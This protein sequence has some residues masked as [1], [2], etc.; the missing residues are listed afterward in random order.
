MSNDLFIKAEQAL[1]NNEFPKAEALF[2]QILSIEPGNPDALNYL[3]VVCFQQGKNEDSLNTF[4]KL[5][6]V[7]PDYPDLSFNLAN[8]LKLTGNYDEAAN[9]ARKAIEA[10]PEIAD[11]YNI[12]AS[13]LKLQGNF[14]E[15]VKNFQA[16]L[17]L[18][19]R[20]FNIYYNLAILLKEQGDLAGAAENYQNAIRLKPSFIQAYYNLAN[21][22]AD[23]DDFT[24]AEINYRKAVELNPRFAKAHYSLAYLYQ[25]NGNLDKAIEHY[26]IT[27]QIEPD[28][29]EACF[30]L[31]NLL[32]ENNR[33][34]QAIELYNKTIS[35]DDKFVKA[36]CNL[37]FAYETLG[38]TEKAKEAFSRAVELDPGNSLLK[39]HLQTMIPVVPFDNRE[40]DQSR[41]NLLYVIGNFSLPKEE[42]DLVNLQIYNVPPSSE[43][44]YQGRDDREIKEKYASLFINLFPLK[45]DAF[46]LAG[47]PQVIR[48]AGLNAS[49]HSR[50]PDIPSRKPRIGF[51]VTRG[52]E[53]IF[54]KCMK[55]ILNN[56]P[57]EKFSYT[58]IFNNPSREADF[59]NGITNPACGFLCM[60]RQFDK[61]V[62]TVEAGNFD[63]LYYWEAGSDTTNYFLPFFRPAP[64]QCTSWGWP[65]TS[66]IP[67]MDYFV[68]SELLETEESQKYYSEKLYKLK[69]L[70][71]FYF[72]S[73]I[74][75]YLTPL[76]FFGLPENRHIY[77]CVQNLRKVHPDFD[78]LISGILQAD[79]DAI[80][81]FSANRHPG[82]TARLKNR[83][84]AKFP[85]LAE[86]IVFIP[87]PEGYE[88]YLSLLANSHVSL[89][90]VHYSGA[91]TTYESFAVGLPVVTLPGLFHRGRYT[92]AA[93]CGMGIMD[94]V[95]KDESDYIQ[96]AVKIATD[97]D[98]RQEL[99]KKIMSSCDILFENKKAIAELT[100]FFEFAL[101][102]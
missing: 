4:K 23:Q 9:Y 2:R 21:I 30:F 10:Q 51:V 25:V 76:S 97:P 69:S 62:K 100:E 44:N 7:K 28:H 40:I 50:H 86:R 68:S 80:V 42:I 66:G 31:A 11:N 52:H 5:L 72:R 82:I 29:A 55:G 90:T 101:N 83:F 6:A 38:L 79:P 14:P 59:R 67:E 19:P 36:H 95:A 78:G 22:C 35:L 57:P 74:P 70:P 8:V 3:A 48:G 98:Y 12:L 20:N 99:S 93:Y 46:P 13:V 84:Q 65:V 60:P 73:P 39:L 17:K 32:A 37:G 15:A 61:A 94:C 77:L 64:V 85:G 96:K 75:Q 43:L 58:I 63:L 47:M 54:I 53:V 56:L 27:L 87:P 24:R 16:A 88:D 45:G 81:V 41:E 33:L 26:N 49:L 89:D 91:N 102:C 71:P 1:Q 18:A 34:E 92:Y